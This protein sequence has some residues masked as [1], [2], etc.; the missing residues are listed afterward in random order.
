MGSLKVIIM[1]WVSETLTA[2]LTGVV[3]VIVGDALSKI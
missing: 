1:L 3:A 2:L